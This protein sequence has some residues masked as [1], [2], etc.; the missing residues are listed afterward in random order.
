MPGD[1]CTAPGVISLSSVSLATDVT[2]GASG[3]WL[4]TRTEA[5]CHRHTS[6]KL[7]LPQPMAP[8]RARMCCL[9]KESVLVYFLN[10]DHLILL[11]QN[12]LMGRHPT[13]GWDDGGKMGKA[14]GWDDGGKIDKIIH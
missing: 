11:K 6:L 1:I 5:V 2:F 3:L 10:F 14:V 9:L 13:V 4:G 8:W 12:I 7:F